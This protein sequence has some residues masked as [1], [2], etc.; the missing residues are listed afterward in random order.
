LGEIYI[1]PH[2]IYQLLQILV[3]NANSYTPDHSIITI[4]SRITKK[5]LIVEVIDHGKG[6]PDQDKARVFDRY[7][8]R[9]PSRNDK[10]HFGLGLNIAK[11]LT[12]LHHGTLT[13]HDTKGG[14]CT[15]QIL[16]PNKAG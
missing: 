16:L 2:R 9:D 14:G 6:I 10:S 11:E 15:F 5:Q 3:N 7:Y 12:H 4:S 1:N 8:R 13:L